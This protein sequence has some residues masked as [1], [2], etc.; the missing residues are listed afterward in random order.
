[1]DIAKHTKTCQELR[2]KGIVKRC[3][4]GSRVVRSGA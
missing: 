3:V 2:A 4:C 1:M